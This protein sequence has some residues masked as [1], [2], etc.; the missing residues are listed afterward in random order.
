MSFLDAEDF[1]IGQ[2]DNILDQGTECT[3]RE[4]G[5]GKSFF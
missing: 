4:Y 5:P 2:Q 3:N 1:D